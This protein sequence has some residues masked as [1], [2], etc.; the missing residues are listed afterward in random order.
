ML[1]SVMS[2]AVSCGPSGA[3]SVMRNPTA[4]AQTRITL[5]FDRIERIRHPDMN[6]RI[7]RIEAHEQP[8]QCL[9]PLLTTHHSF[10]AARTT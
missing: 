3:H 2:L 6:T 9:A 4:P 7:M 10:E 8:I 5:Y 1:Q